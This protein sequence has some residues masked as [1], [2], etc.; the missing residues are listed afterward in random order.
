MRFLR[1]PSTLALLGLALW[2]AVSAVLLSEYLYRGVTVTWDE[3]S[4]LFQA[5]HFASGKI[6]DP[7]PEILVEELSR[8]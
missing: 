2:A 5:H 6:K 7:Y 8:G 1:S 4:Y 3:S